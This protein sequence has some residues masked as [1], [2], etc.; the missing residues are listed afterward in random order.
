MSKLNTDSY[1]PINTVAS[2]PPIGTVTTEKNT[3]KGSTSR[4]LSTP[5]DTD[6][7]ALNTGTLDAVKA[8]ASDGT[9]K[10]ATD[11]TEGMKIAEGSEEFDLTVEELQAAI[12][13]MVVINGGKLDP[14]GRT[15][16]KLTVKQVNKGLKA[17]DTIIRNKGIDGTP[18]AKALRRL[19]KLVNNDTNHAGKLE[20]LARM[21]D[22]TKTINVAKGAIGVPVNL[23]FTNNPVFLSDYDIFKAAD[24]GNIEYENPPTHKATYDHKGEYGLNN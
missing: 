19:Q 15:A 22:E 6:T 24:E 21:V 13:A 17:T 12:R 1:T 8:G 23:K 7:V 4:L 18:E 14:S 16:Y 2:P 11:S 5:A 10:Y 3:D 9:N 20:T